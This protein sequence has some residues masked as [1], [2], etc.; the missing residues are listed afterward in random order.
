MTN[1]TKLLSEPFIL[2]R[3]D[4]KLDVIEGTVIAERANTSE[5]IN[6]STTHNS[7]GELV[8]V[9]VY[10]NTVHSHDFFIKES[11][12]GEEIHVLYEANK[13]PIRAG[14]LVRVVRAEKNKKSNGKRCVGVRNLSLPSESGQSVSRNYLWQLL[15][16]KMPE[17]HLLICYLMSCVLFYACVFANSE[18]GGALGW[19]ISAL[20]SVFLCWVPYL[21]IYFIKVRPYLSKI[22]GEI[23]QMLR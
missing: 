7:R 15:N 18:S 20:A 2:S 5:Q 22:E 23:V 3:N 1:N 19:G 13:L 10:S 6:T 11:T 4:V 21:G 17:R 12:T 16:L 8:G 14:H 9:D